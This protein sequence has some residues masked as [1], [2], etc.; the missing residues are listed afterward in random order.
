MSNDQSLDI[1]ILQS[2]KDINIEIIDALGKEVERLESVI[3]DKVT[4]LETANKRIAELEGALTYMLV[5]FCD[6]DTDD[7][8]LPPEDQRNECLTIAMGVLDDD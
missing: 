6:R 3:L 5:E 4:D 7:D 8:P 1:E 2:E